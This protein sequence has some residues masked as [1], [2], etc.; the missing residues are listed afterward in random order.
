[1]VRQQRVGRMRDLV[2]EVRTRLLWRDIRIPYS[3][4]DDIEVDVPRLARRAMQDA[5]VVMSGR[6]PVGVPQTID[7]RFLLGQVLIDRLLAMVVVQTV[8]AGLTLL[9]RSPE[10]RRRLRHRLLAGRERVW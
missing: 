1:M 7:Q 5:P 2:Q 8:V 9:D 10:G 3:R 4:R 6:V